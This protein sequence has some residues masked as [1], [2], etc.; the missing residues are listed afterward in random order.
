MLKIWYHTIVDKIITYDA[1]T[2]EGHLTKQ[3]ITTLI[4]LQRMFLLI[5]PRGYK[6][7]S[8]DALN[9]IRGISPNLNNGEGGGDI[10]ST[11]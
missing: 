2:W 3:A 4:S 5:I 9:T 10:C 1:S 11:D 6:I 8:T 7:I